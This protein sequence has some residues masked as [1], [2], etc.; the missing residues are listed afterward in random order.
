MFASCL[1]DEQ[2]EENNAT[3]RRFGRGS[4]WW[5]ADDE[6]LLDA[7]FIKAYTQVQ[8]RTK[9]APLLRRVFFLL[10]LSA[11]FEHDDARHSSRL[12]SMVAGWNEVEGRRVASYEA[13]LFQSRFK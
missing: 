1:S 12:L 7:V 6:R 10:F 9:E 8:R 4:S 3:S 5:D 2:N 11:E 13:T